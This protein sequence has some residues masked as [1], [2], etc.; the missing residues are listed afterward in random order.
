[1]GWR[2]LDSCNR[3]VLVSEVGA[4][5]TVKAIHLKKVSAGSRVTAV[6]NARKRYGHRQVIGHIGSTHSGAELVSQAHLTKEKIYHNQQAL[7]LHRIQTVP[8]LRP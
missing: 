7:N 8:Q 1:M 5:R 2:Y 6:Q 3:G 4:N